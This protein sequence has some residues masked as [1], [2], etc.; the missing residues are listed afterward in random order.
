MGPQV[1]EDVMLIRGIESRYSQLTLIV[2][3]QQPCHLHI[4][5]L[6]MGPTTL[7]LQ[8]SWLLFYVVYSF[9]DKDYVSSIESGPTGELKETIQSVQSVFLPSCDH[10]GAQDCEGKIFQVSQLVDQNGDHHRDG[11]FSLPTNACRYKDYIEWILAPAE[12][13]ETTATN[14]TDLVKF[15]F[16]SCVKGV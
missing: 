14:F 3:I 10:Q 2:L 11:V 15:R 13:K 12:E 16:Y 5:V 1:Q 8:C 4:P 6:I 7:R 9:S